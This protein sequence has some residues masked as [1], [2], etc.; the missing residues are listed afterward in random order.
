[1]YTISNAFNDYHCN[2]SWV[3]DILSSL[4]YGGCL[5]GYISISIMVDNMGRK[6]QC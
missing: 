1:M 2:K 5:F 3:P 4:V 6:K